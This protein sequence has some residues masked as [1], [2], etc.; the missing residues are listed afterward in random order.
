MRWT[1]KRGEVLR[2]QLLA[3]FGCRGRTFP[4]R[5]PGRSAYQVVVAKTLLQ[6][7]TASAVARAYTPFLNRYPSW[8]RL[9]QVSREALRPLGSGGRRPTSCGSSHAPSRR[10]AERPRRR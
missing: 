5:E 7:T 4:W 10:L 2:E 8:S 9:A 6:R 3:W 1:S